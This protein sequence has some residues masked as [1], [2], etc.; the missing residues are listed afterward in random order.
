MYSIWYMLALNWCI[1]F[2]WSYHRVSQ[3]ILSNQFFC[4]NHFFMEYDIL[5]ILIIWVNKSIGLSFRKK[6]IKKKNALLSRW[7][8]ETCNLQSYLLQ[9]NGINGTHIFSTLVYWTLYN[10]L[11]SRHFSNLFKTKNE[12]KLGQSSPFDPRPNYNSISVVLCLEEA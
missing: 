11:L 8:H 7:D 5:I 4:K 6:E 2:W 3:R 9:M 12:A 10:A 1:I